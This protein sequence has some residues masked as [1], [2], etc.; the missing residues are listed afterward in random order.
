MSLTTYNELQSSIADWTNRTDLTSQ[1]KDFIAITE[2][3]MYREL[4]CPL[5]EK[6]VNLFLGADSEASIP[7]DLIEIKDIFYKELP[8][9]R[10]SLGELY[11]YVDQSGTPTVYARKGGKLVFFPS[12]TEVTA[13]DLQ[14]NYYYQM[15]SLSDSVAVNLIFQYAPELF[16]YGALREAATF[17]GQDPSVWD[18]RYS[19]AMQLLMRHTRESETAGSTPIMESGYN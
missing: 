14:I 6:I 3:R 4:K 13:G 17:L 7:N 10:V 2:S 15:P 16:L 18:A 1:I 12:K 8:L 11:K 5:N 9:Q 19:E